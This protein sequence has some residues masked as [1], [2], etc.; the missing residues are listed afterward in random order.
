MSCPPLPTPPDPPDPQNP[1][2][3]TTPTVPSTV[4]CS[5]SGAPSGGGTWPIIN[6]DIIIVNNYIDVTTIYVDIIYA[7]TI[8]VTNVYVDYITIN[9]YLTW[10]PITIISPVN[11]TF[12]WDITINRPV[13]YLDGII[14]PLG[15]SCDAGV[16][17]DILVNVPVYGTDYIRFSSVDF[18]VHPDTVIPDEDMT[19]V[20]LVPL[21]VQAEVNNPTAPFPVL[22]AKTWSFDI[23]DFKVSPDGADPYQ[24]D[25]ELLSHLMV[26]DD[27]ID[28]GPHIPVHPTNNIT[29]DK[30]SFLVYQ[31]DGVD[32][33]A[34]VML[35]L[36]YKQI[37]LGVA[38]GT[39]P[40]KVQLN[41]DA[42]ILDSAGRVEVIG[43]Y[44]W[45]LTGPATTGGE[46][47]IFDAT[48]NVWRPQE[49]SQDAE[50]TQDGFVTVTGWRDW[51]LDEGTMGNP[52]D[53]QMPIFNDSDS[54]WYARTLSLDVYALDS[55]GAL[56]VQGL[57]KIPMDAGTIGA[58][59]NFDM[60]YY[61]GSGGKWVA[62]TLQSILSNAAVTSGYNGSV[63][64][65]LG[66]SAAG[67]LTWYN[68][69]TC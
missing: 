36:D 18:K 10:I 21:R 22:T 30:D 2:P 59:A 11:Y 37:Y 34:D 7:T 15:M 33:Q 61:L 27:T 23:K 43:F 60:I 4:P 3:E 51:Q 17:D 29:F 31:E 6:V 47:Y 56:V 1:L 13:Y 41:K 65:L 50:M 52:T 45:P 12:W 9:N 55:T 20:Q 25:I 67:A 16:I 53:A 44:S 58:P 63:I 35:N 46:I 57:Q 48:D 66:H 68:V 38:T 8:N 5:T 42:H 40:A 32:D 54:M 24:A 62:G 26:N 19:T 64:Q 39:A 69:S 28:P 14:Y 49:L